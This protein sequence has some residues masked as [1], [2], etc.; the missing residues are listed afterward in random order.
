VSHV[1]RRS[2]RPFALPPVSWWLLAYSRPAWTKHP[3]EART[4][5][6]HADPDVAADA[7]HFDDWNTWTWDCR[8]TAFI[9]GRLAK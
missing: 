6:R 1:M 7:V 9:G 4:L 3:D 2:Q 5:V 8:G